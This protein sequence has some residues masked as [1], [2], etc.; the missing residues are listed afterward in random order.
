M[1]TDRADDLKRTEDLWPLVVEHL[2]H[3]CNSA[4][5]GFMDY[6]PDAS[7]LEEKFRRGE[8]EHGRDWLN[9]TREQF[10][11]EILDEMRDLVIYHAMRMARWGDGPNG[12]VRP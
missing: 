8:A 6:K 5:L 1:A 11:E 4:V 10:D 9:M 2:H 7:M 12:W 3:A